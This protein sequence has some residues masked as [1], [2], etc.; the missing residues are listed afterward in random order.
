MREN[1][2]RW[3]GYTQRRPVDALVKRSDMLPTGLEGET[4]KRDMTKFNMSWNKT[5]RN[6]ISQLDIDR[7]EGPKSSFKETEVSCRFVIVVIYN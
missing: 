5:K 7:R 1:R 6:V 3:F 4:A 2:L